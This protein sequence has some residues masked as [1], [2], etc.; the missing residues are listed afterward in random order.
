V[1]SGRKAVATPEEEEE[2][3]EDPEAGLEIEPEVESEELEAAEVPQ[4]AVN[5][6]AAT[7]LPVE[8]E[9]EIDPAATDETETE[10]DTET[11]ANTATQAK[12]AKQAK[13]LGNLAVSNKKPVVSSVEYETVSQEP[14]GVSEPSTVGDGSEEEAGLDPVTEEE[15][16]VERE[17]FD[18]EE[19]EED[20]DD[21][22]ARDYEDDDDEDDE[23]DDEE[24]YGRREVVEYTE[25]GYYDQNG[26]FHLYDKR[27]I[28][29]D[30]E[31]EE[32]EEDDDDHA[33][34]EEAH[35]LYRTDL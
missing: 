29:D 28:D 12:Q 9:D 31:F 7:A 11:G 35:F 17:Y 1:G 14:Y 15:T 24:H 3:V 8:S 4:V 6:L 19:D 10:T 27:D 21:L 30:G 2:V 34:E 18:E 22:Y 5:R 32:E 25:N 23:D 20:V 33:D 26:E 16:F 13:V